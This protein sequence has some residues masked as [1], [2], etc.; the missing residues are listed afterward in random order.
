VKIRARDWAKWFLGS[1]PGDEQRVHPGQVDEGWMESVGVAAKSAAGVNVT[2]HSSLQNTAV[3]A[4]VRLLAESVGSLPLILYKRLADGGKARATER[5][6]YG[7]LH[8]L[9]NPEMTSIQLRETLQGH[10]GLWGNAYCEIEYAQGGYVRGLWPLR[11]DKVQVRRVKGELVYVVSMPQGPDQALAFENVMHIPGFGYDGVVGYSPI[12]LARQAIGLAMATEEY[13]SRFFGNGARPGGV[14]KHPLKLSEEAYSRLSKSWDRR[15]QG[16]ENSQR[17]AILEEGMDYAAIGIPPED[18]QFLETR[19][20]Q[21]NEI[22]RLYRIPPHMIGDLDRATFSNIE[23]QGIEF[24]VHTLQP[25]LVRWEQAI[26]RDLLS[27]AERKTYF[28]EHLVT[29]LL[30]GDTKSRYEA[31]AVGRQNGWLSANDVRELENMNPVDGGDVYLVPLNMV[32]AGDVGSSPPNP[33]EGGD[34]TDARNHPSP[35]PSPLQGRGSQVLT[36]GQSVEARARDFGRSRLRL[37]KSYEKVMRD[38]IGRVV[39]R[40]VNDVRRAARKYLGKRDA[41]QFGQWLE[42]FY[43]DHREFWVDQVMPILLNF[44]DQVGAN[45]G[46]E[47]DLAAMDGDEIQEFI[48]QYAEKMAARESQSSL[49]QLKALLDEAIVAGE[50]PLDL[51]DTRLEEWSEKRPGK[52]SREES[53][54][55]VNAIS[56]AFYGLAAVT[57]GYTIKMMWVAN[58]DSCP[59]C[60]SLDGKIVGIEE[61]FVEKGQEFQPDGAERPLSRRVNI[62]HGPLHTGCDCGV[63]AVVE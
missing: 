24:V 23:H 54:S 47:L 42:D 59:Y 51:V 31:Y 49:L 36:P 30:R 58:G 2:P 55:G 4:C 11:P 10:L 6:L 34:S 3:F 29:A 5:P 26:Y 46:D 1:L 28:A 43:R 50:D 12:T 40:E 60:S 38:P 62:S 41:V 63:V 22:A 19:K 20:F 18:A 27:Q 48:E 57:T 14:L 9:P 25:W 33:P 13:G 61:V 15:H 8:D 32:P 39:R 21:V 7:L 52:L 37:A 16:L 53:R 44:A 35:Q 17:V 45:V 56:I